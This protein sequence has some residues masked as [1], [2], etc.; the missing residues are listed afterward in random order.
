MS[1]DE[2][3]CKSTDGSFRGN[4]AGNKV[5]AVPRVSVYSSND[6]SL[7]PPRGET[8]GNQSATRFPAVSSGNT[9]PHISV[10]GS[11]LMADWML[12]SGYSQVHVGE[13]ESMWP[14]QRTSSIPTP[15]PLCS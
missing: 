13:W 14:S 6:K 10:A 9:A 3:L 4:I 8:Q 12:G 7:S 15:R 11:V 5:K 1:G 2:A